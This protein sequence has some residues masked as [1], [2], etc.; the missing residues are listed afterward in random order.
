MAFG[1]EAALSA[2]R[3]KPLLLFYSSALSLAVFSGAATSL[4]RDYYCYLR[5]LLVMR[6]LLEGSLAEC[7]CSS[8]CESIESLADIR[9]EAMLSKP[10]SCELPAG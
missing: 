2:A 1:C 9:C 7:C 3:S 5:E 10:T 4:S 8:A 6:L